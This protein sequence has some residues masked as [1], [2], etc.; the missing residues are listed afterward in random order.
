MLVFSR[1][2]SDTHIQTKIQLN[3]LSMSTGFLWNMNY[4]A[5]DLEGV[6]P[7]PEY[8]LLAFPDRHNFYI[9]IVSLSDRKKRAETLEAV[10]P[11][12]LRSVASSR[13]GSPKN[14]T[15]AGLNGVTGCSTRI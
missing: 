7:M 15:G 10:A 14:A 13:T 2:S 11:P 5:R 6:V 12:W 8:D 3:F 4:D 9:K 1:E